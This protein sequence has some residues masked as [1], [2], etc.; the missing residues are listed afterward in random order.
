MN[1]KALLAEFIGTLG[2]LFFILMGIHSQIGLL[3]VAIG[4]GVTI[5]ALGTAL[6]PI[7]G[8]HFNPCVTV[9]MVAA[10]KISFMTALGYIIVQC[11]GGIAGV[12]LAGRLTADFDTAVLAGKIQWGTDIMMWQ[13]LSAEAVAA[14]LFVLV[15]FMTAV[16]SRAPKNGALYLGLTLTMGILAIGP[17]SGAAI[18]PAVGVAMSVANNS[19]ETVMSWAVGPLVGGLL[20]AL[21]YRGFFEEKTAAA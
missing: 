2:L 20:A 18:N 17:I 15:V 10:G 21:V 1:I 14:F 11:A 5:L 19:F 12:F 7:S 16:D 4:V 6:G 3:G 8:G 13:A 9:A